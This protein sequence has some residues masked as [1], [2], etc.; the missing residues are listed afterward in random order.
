MKRIPIIVLILA[1]LAGFVQTGLAAPTTTDQYYPIMKGD[2]DMRSL[3]SQKDM[4]SSGFQYGAWITPVIIYQDTPGNEL[5]TSVTTFRAW[6]K[7]YLWQD[8]FLYVR[9]KDTYTAILYHK[10]SSAAKDKNVYD[11]DLGYIDMA[12]PRKEFQI[13]VGRKY[14]LLGSGTIMNGRGDGAEINVNT[15]YLNI[16]ALGAWTGWLA[17]DDNPYGLS[18]RDITRGAKRVFTGGT[19][20]TSWFNQTLYAFGLA[21]FDFGKEQYDF[22]NFL[23][24]AVLPATPYADGMQYFNTRTRYES[25]YYRR[26]P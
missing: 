24:C 23:L 13:S 21:Q 7:T 10:G 4:L 19:L 5:V 2:E 1:A 22:E 17:K 16:K 8:S 14:F 11:L 20:S 25:Q 18:D 26:G 15:K 3:K 6:M 12:T 9:G